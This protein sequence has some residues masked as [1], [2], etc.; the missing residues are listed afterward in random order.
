MAKKNKNEKEL[1]SKW[2]EDWV[3]IKNIL[4]GMIALEN[5]EYVTGIKVGQEIMLFINYKIFIIQL[6][7]NFGW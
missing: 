1:L 6:I 4:N 2:S 3:P 5:G 7:L